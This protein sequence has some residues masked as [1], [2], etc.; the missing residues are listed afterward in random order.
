MPLVDHDRAAIETTILI[1]LF[2]SD[3]NSEYN[4]VKLIPHPQWHT[5]GFHLKPE[6]G[7]YFRRSRQQPT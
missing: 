1:G 3:V 6:P 7:S 2:L 5:T 4:P